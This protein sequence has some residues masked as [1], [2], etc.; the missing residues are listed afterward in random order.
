MKINHLALASLIVLSGLTGGA[1]LA[2]EDGDGGGGRHGPPPEAISACEG[3]ATND[4]CEFDGRRGTVTGTCREVPDGFAC[5]PEHRPG[6][7]PQ[8]DGG[9]A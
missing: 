3:A 1:A 7:A 4:A 5:V 2:C 6:N 8:V 9:S